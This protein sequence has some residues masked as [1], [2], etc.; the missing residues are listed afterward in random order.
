M[1]TVAQ[2]LGSLKMT[3]GPRRGLSDPNWREEAGEL[4]LPPMLISPS[5]GCVSSSQISPQRCKSSQSEAVEHHTAKAA[6]RQDCQQWRF[7]HAGGA[8]VSIYLHPID[9]AKF[10]IR[11]VEEAADSKAEVRKIGIAWLRNTSKLG[12]ESSLLPLITANLIL[13]RMAGW[14]RQ[15]SKHS[16]KQKIYKNTFLLRQR[17]QSDHLLSKPVLQLFA[18]LCLCGKNI[19]V[20]CS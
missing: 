11:P 9:Y 17:L 1:I 16:D 20:S 6:K 4:N 19:M 18:S 12:L 2:K 15:P 13:G 14:L 8:Y 10:L 7:P 5:P 3:N